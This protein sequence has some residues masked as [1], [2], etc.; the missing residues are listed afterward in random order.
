MAW[1]KPLSAFTSDGQLIGRLPPPPSD[2]RLMLA[3]S[4]QFLRNRRSY[5]SG[6]GGLRV[7]RTIGVGR[8]LSPAR[9]D[10]KGSRGVLEGAALGGGLVAGEAVEELATG[11]HVILQDVGSKLAATFLVVAFEGRIRRAQDGKFPRYQFIG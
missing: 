8:G 9:L 3:L 7:S 5:L 10:E 11:D 4:S 1:M 2:F 6:D